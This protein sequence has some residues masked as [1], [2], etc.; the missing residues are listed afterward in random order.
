MINATNSLT[1]YEL[2]SLLASV[3]GFL[4]VILTLVLLIRQ[5]RL[6]TESL[7][8]ATNATVANLQF[9][10][11]M[12]SV[13]RP[14]LRKYLL[15]N[16]SINPDQ[17]EFNQVSAAAQCLLDF[18]E[19]YVVQKDKFSLLYSPETWLAYIR[20]HFANSPALC[21]FLRKHKDWYSGELLK[22]MEESGSGDDVRHQRGHKTGTRTKG[23]S[24]PSGP[25]AS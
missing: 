18:F 16:E 12:I 3:A 14:H 13:E 20:T 19:V 15:G 5:T 2:L 24:E 6:Q 7:T 11:D 21:A 23:G 1:L 17:P 10:A 4:V 25:E 9:Q 8:A 22:I